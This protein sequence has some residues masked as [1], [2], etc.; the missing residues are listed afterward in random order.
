MRFFLALFLLVTICSA[1]DRVQI[2]AKAI[3]KAEGFKAN[4]KNIPTRYHNPGD[5]KTVKGYRYPSQIGIGKG[6]HVIFRNNAAGWAA[7][8]RQI[9]RI[10]SG[11]SHYNVNMSLEDMSKK[12]AGNWNVWANNVARALKMPTNTPLWEILDVPPIL[13]KEKPM[14]TFTVTDNN[15][16]K[17]EVQADSMRVERNTV[18]LFISEGYQDVAAFYK[19]V[20]VL[21]NIE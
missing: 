13:E 12:Y 14:K 4:N 5:L 20:S 21:K 19:P 8:S 18:I 2:L 1:Q 3:A 6:G 11:T 9:E 10:I 7:L 16:N 17:K 15:G